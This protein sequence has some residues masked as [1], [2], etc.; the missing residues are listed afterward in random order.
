[1]SNS[2]LRFHHIHLISEHP[3]AAARWYE[4]I[5]GG[6]IVGE[7]DVRGAPQII[8]RLG[9]MRL[10]I[11]GRRPGEEPTAT[12]GMRAYDGFSSHN[13]WGTDHFGYDYHGDLQ[14][15]CD[16]LRA[17]GAAFAA[18][19]WEFAPGHLICFVQAPDRVTIELMAAG[20]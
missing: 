17:K 16:E 12:N 18:E 19:P 1:M 14:A 20:D 3:Q 2:R 5:L 7:S 10:L 4:N 6:E 15:F 9:G 8:V 13:E 11:R